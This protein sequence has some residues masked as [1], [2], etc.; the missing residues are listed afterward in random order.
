LKFCILY[1]FFLS[2]FILKAQ[3]NIDSLKDALLLSQ[4]D[5]LKIKTL[6]RISNFYNNSGN[7]D[8]LEKYVTATNSLAYINYLKDSTSKT[9]INHFANSI[10]YIGLYKNKQAKYSDAI[11]QYQ[12]AENLH[13]KNNNLDRLA[14]VYND[15][16]IVYKSKREYK[17]ALNNYLKSYE[18]RELLNDSKNMAGVLHNIGHIYHSLNNLEFAIKYVNKAIPINKLNSNFNWLGFN[19]NELGLI[20]KELGK[21]K[22]AEEKFSISKK[23]FEKVG[24]SEGISGVESNL[25]DLY[26]QNNEP[27]KALNSYN[28]FLKDMIRLNNTS[29]LAL[30]YIN[31]GKA[32][33]KL[34][35]FN[36]A[37][38]EIN[39]AILIANNFSQF[40]LLEE[41]HLYLVKIDS[42]RNNF[43]SAFNNFK[44]Y[45]KYKDSVALEKNNK[46]VIETKYQTEYATMHITDS[47]KSV[48]ENKINEL[49]INEE[50]TQ[51]KLLTGFIFVIICVVIFILN[52]YKA[53]Q[54]QRK[55]IEQ[56]KTEVEIKQKEILESINYAKRIQQSL[57]PTNKYL[58]RNIKK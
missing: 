15:L 56:Q 41:A 37:Y 5:S 1:L 13:R 38:E 53:S 33:I 20:Y 52:R 11:K 26:L 6:F 43:K 21:Y 27:N 51:K 3:N 31:I 19:Y 39:K 57:L 9:N 8:S 40:D 29:E 28:I 4:N 2:G 23:Y 32:Y 25:G 42:S 54:K 46:K 34:K 45:I 16:G 12:K 35:K 30:A 14:I 50:K 44:L 22:I 58:E 24:F 17:L 48:E 55:I 18:I 10:M 7:I 36:I 49:K 47:I